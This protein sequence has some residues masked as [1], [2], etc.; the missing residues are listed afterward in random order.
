M[1]KEKTILL[2]KCNHS[3]WQVYAGRNF[4]KCGKCSLYFRYHDPEEWTKDE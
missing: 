1:N 4:F 2:E 3:L